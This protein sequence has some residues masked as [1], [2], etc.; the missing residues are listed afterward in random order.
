MSANSYHG[1]VF[2]LLVLQ[3]P[4]M[5]G[6]DRVQVQI[7]KRANTETDFRRSYEASSH[8]TTA[9]TS[10]CDDA[11]SQ[12]TCKGSATTSTT[13]SPAG[14]YGYIVNGAT[15]ALKVPDGRFAIVNCESKYSLKFDFV[16]CRSCKVP[17]A[18]VVNAEFVGGNVKLSWSVSLD[19]KRFETELYKVLGILETLPG[20]KETGTK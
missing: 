7:V 5:C 2:I 13:H 6:A 17:P 3:L 19:G 4:E 12:V 16:N 9:A 20:E 8:S 18:D 1:T 14:V 11:S 10:A 15:L